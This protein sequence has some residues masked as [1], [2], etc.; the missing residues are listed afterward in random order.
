MPPL[1]VLLHAHYVQLGILLRSRVLLCALYALQGPMHHSRELPCALCVLLGLSHP[2][3]GLTCALNV[4]L[5]FL[6]PHKGLLFAHSVLLVH[7]RL[8]LA[9]PDALPYLLM[10][11]L[12]PFLSALLL[13][14]SPLLCKRPLIAACMAYSDKHWQR[15]SLYQL[16]QW[17]LYTLLQLAGC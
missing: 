17:I 15:F 4:H 7:I 12:P 16:I 9:Q 13:M 2:L 14:S 10:F 8:L 3:R 5:V 6:R 1:R 11:L